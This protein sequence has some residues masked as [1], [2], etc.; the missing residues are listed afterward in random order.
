MEPPDRLAGMS[1]AVEVLT[2]A[3]EQGR[4]V[5]IV[6]DF[7]CDGATST[8]LA[9]TALEAMA[10]RV[11]YVVPDRFRFGYGLTPAIVEEA[12]ST[13][14]PHV[15]VTVDNGISSE[16]GIAEAQERGME[17]VVT[18]HHLPPGSLPPADAIVN[19]NQPDCAFPSKSAAGVGVIFYVMAGLRARLRQADWFRRQGLEE[20]RLG[21]LLDLVAVG[22]VA[23]VV[24]L[25]RNNRV[26]VRQGLERLR[27]GQARPGLR[28][29][30]EVAGREPRHIQAQDLG[31]VVGPRLNAAGRL[32]DMSLGIRCLLAEDEATARRC[33]EELDQLNSQRRSLEATMHD[34]ALEGLASDPSLA[35]RQGVC[36]F[37]RDWHPGIVGL[38]ASRIKERLHRPVI[39]FAPDEYGGLKGSGR[40]VPG[41]HMRDALARLAM[42]E[43]GLVSRF[44]GHAMAAGLTV[45]YEALEAFQEAFD[46]AV[47]RIAA[48]EAL[49]PRLETDGS[50]DLAELTLDKA[51]LLARGGPWGTGFPAP[52]FRGGFRVMRQ[53]LVGDRHLKMWLAPEGAETAKVE[54]IYFGAAVDG[55]PLATSWIEALYHLEVNV[56][57]NRRRLQLRI[58]EAVGE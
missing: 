15:L 18:D 17:V 10:G 58:V 50:L 8:A 9:V 30:M 33:A 42:D 20:P 25:D 12:A 37:R 43:P 52:L 2:R 54:A 19:P 51:E 6:G 55:E 32:E 13:V 38:V 22:T 53:Q 1:A 56:F 29:L 26:L 14:A 21:D 35:E 48:P 36:L 5:C 39:A 41:V 31:F 47:A 28:A 45:P 23:D 44:G 27:A 46:R 57:R 11:T 34:D 4:T 24:P 7:D 49:T 16:G 3:L 40:S